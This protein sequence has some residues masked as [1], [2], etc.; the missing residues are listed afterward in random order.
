MADPLTREQHAIIQAAL[1]AA[2]VRRTNAGYS[3]EWGDREAVELESIVSAWT[4]GLKGE[5]PPQLKEYQKQ[6]IRES[7]PDYQTYLKMKEKFE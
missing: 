5:V 3:G 7:D 4:Y 2:E 6:V 1:K